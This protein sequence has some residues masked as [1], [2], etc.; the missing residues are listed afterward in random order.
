MRPPFAGHAKGSQGVL[1]FI[2]DQVVE[3]A[4]QLNYRACY[5]K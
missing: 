3:L 1:G 4:L 2:F 5:L